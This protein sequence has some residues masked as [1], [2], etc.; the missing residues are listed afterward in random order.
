MYNALK[1][2]DF[3]IEHCPPHEQDK[4]L[5][6]NEQKCQYSCCL[7]LLIQEHEF[8]GQGIYITRQTCVDISFLRL[9]DHQTH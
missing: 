7:N 3:V 5:Y 6:N 2:I 9:H 1:N 4:D 8:R